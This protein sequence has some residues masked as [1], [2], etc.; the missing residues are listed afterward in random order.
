VSFKEAKPTPSR[1]VLTI[2]DPAAVRQINSGDSMQTVSAE[3][4]IMSRAEALRGPLLNGAAVCG[5]LFK[6]VDV[7]RGA[8]F[9]M[10][11]EKSG[12]GDGE[13]RI[14]V[15]AASTEAGKNLGFGITCIKR[16]SPVTS[17]DIQSS[18]RGII[19]VN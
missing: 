9:K 3:G 10:A 14:Y 12:T 18:F 4:R 15:F 16:G 2:K 7:V 11:E 1:Y 17:A 6:D 19:D 13:E 5:A 8:S